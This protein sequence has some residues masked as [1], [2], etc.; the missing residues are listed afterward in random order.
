MSAGVEGASLEVLDSQD[1]VRFEQLVLPH[2]D[3]AF[4]LARWLMHGR[5]DAEDIAQEA[6]MR[7]LGFCRSCATLV[8][9]GWRKIDPWTYRPNSMKSCTRSRA[10][11]PKRWLLPA[12]TASSSRA[13][14]RNFPRVF[15]KCWSCANSRAVP[16]RRLPP[17]LPLPSAR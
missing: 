14:S 16:I 12:I 10:F 2:L 4:N 6:M 3:A 5:A 7:A 15:A 1:R 8:I 13:R 11:R 9:R 17:L